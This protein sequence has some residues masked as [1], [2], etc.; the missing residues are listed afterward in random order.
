MNLSLAEIGRGHDPACLLKLPPGKRPFTFVFVRHPLT[1]YRSYWACRM[2]NHRWKVHPRQRITGWQTFGS[3]LDHECRSNDFVKWMQNVLAYVPE[4]FLS[5]VYR[6]YTEDVDFVGKV[7]SLQDDLYQALRLAGEKIPPG[8]IQPLSK[9]NAS[10]P[11]FLEAARF[12]MELAERVMAA[13]SYVV[14]RWDYTSI[15]ESVIQTDNKPRK[16][17]LSFSW[18]R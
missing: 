5:R 1:W 17:F 6:I 18:V 11:K 16:H 4:G 9:D 8:E 15:P 14:Q 13:E 12:P 10:L 7:E 2:M 3:V